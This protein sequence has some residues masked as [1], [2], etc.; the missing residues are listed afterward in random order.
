MANEVRIISTLKDNV[1]GPL[2]KMQ[3]KFDTLGKS[4]GFASIVS[5]VG[6]GIGVSAWGMASTAIVGFIGDSIKAASDLSESQSKVGVVFSQSAE[7]VRAWAETAAKS[8]GLSKQ[9]ALESSSTLGNLLLSMGKTSDE[10]ADMSMTMV[11][12]AADLA[13]FNNVDIEEVLMAMR[14][15]L[16]GEI[17]PLRRFGVNLTEA[18]LKAEA[19]ALGVSDGKKVLDAS[20]KSAAAYSLILKQTTTA[21]GDFARTS[22]G[23]A[24]Q[25]RILNAELD[26]T[27]A[28]LG[29]QIIPAFIG[30]QRAALGLFGALDVLSDG[31]A[32]TT[33]G[34]QQQVQSSIDL[35]RAIA[36]LVPGAGALA[37]AEQH[38]LDEAKKIPPGFDAAGDSSVNMADKVRS[39]AFGNGGVVKSMDGMGDA[40]TDFRDTYRD[41]TGDII[42][43]SKRMADKLVDDA[44]RIRGEV[45]DE[46]ELRA[47]LHD[48]R[49]DLHALAE[50]RRDAKTAE[51]KRQATDDIIQALDDQG[52]KLE[53]LA[54]IGKLTS[55]DVDRFE[56]DAKASYK[57]LSK[58]GRHQLDLLIARYRTLAGMPN[59]KKTFTISQRGLTGTH[60]GGGGPQEFN[61]AGFVGTTKGPTMGP[62]GWMGEAGTEAVAILRNPKP[63]PSG[64]VGGVSSGSAAPVVINVYAGIGTSFTAAEGRR[65]ADAILPPLL[66]GMQRKGHLPRTGTG[67]TG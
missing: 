27:S 23:L 2:G 16:T 53:D 51:E 59:I 41:V 57:S 21:Q 25:Q 19:M 10:A 1:T 38:M 3:D 64:G 12:L 55:K 60:A 4:K 44:A 40:A 24:N 42:R 18:A 9:A 43:R 14:S 47:D 36:I 11:K 52:G 61:A 29:T 6:L 5:G 31:A 39:A 49:M 50:Q 34:Q 35:A 56:R 65:L 20:Q 37:E 54:S 32:K 26:D 7:K 66:A 67:L 63:I 28:K 46:T 30:A 48:Q 45:F 62:V 15:G 58:E 22:T 8:M 17:A 33:E 13:S